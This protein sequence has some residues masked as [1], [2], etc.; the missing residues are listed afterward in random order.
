MTILFTAIPPIWQSY[1]GQA[2]IA[3]PPNPQTIES[4]DMVLNIP[5]ASDY[6]YKYLDSDIED[7]NAVLY[8]SLYSDLRYYDM[9]MNA[10][11]E[12]KRQIAQ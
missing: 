11:N 12:V 3:I 5:V 6:F 10:S 7:S 8:Y 9:Q 4:L 1:K 2:Y